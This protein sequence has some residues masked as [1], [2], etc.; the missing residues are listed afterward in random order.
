MGSHWSSAIA[1]VLSFKRRVY[2]TNCWKGIWP[3]AGDYL[4]NCL[5]GF[6]K[7][8][9]GRIWQ[10]AQGCTWEFADGGVFDKL[11]WGGGGW[12]IW[13]TA[14]MVFDKL[15]GGYLTNYSDGIWHAVGGGVSY[16][17]LNWFLTNCWESI[18]QT[19]EWGNGKLLNGVFDKLEARYLTHCWKGYLTKH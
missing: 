7:L 4:A 15:F 14:G 11:L 16:K 17:L 6:D 13:W 5:R 10:I 3:T 2:L 19:V 1:T 9:G 12:G 18:W 8:L